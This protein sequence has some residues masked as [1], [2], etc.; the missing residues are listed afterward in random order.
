MTIGGFFRNDFIA[1]EILQPLAACVY[2]T[3]DRHF[4]ISHVVEVLN[5]VTLLQ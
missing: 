2:S 3:A 5:I 1:R 4:P